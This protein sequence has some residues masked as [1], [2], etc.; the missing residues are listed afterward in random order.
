[1]NLGTI[2]R[3]DAW[4]VIASAERKPP[5]IRL[6]SLSAWCLAIAGAMVLALAAPA[7]GACLAGDSDCDGVLDAFDLCPGTM[8][9]EL[10]ATNGCSVCPCD[11]PSAGVPWASHTAY[12]N[13]ATSVAN[14]RYLAGLLTKTAKT[15]VIKHAQSSTCGT[16]NI[17]CCTWRRPGV[18][19]SMGTCSMMAATSCTFPNLGKWAENRATGS[20]YYNPCTW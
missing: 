8:A 19:G 9:L 11:G 7:F 3:S 15:N 12:V 5:M 16:A 17:R 1:M 20:C 18:T 6:K 13:C 10:V 2:D 14:Q 4:T